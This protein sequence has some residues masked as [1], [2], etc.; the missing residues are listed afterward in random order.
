MVDRLIERLDAIAVEEPE[1]SEPAKSDKSNQNRPIF[2]SAP[3]VRYSKLAFRRLVR[4]YDVDC[5]YT[6]MIYAKCHVD[7]EK[8]RQ[9]EFSTCPEDRPLIVQFAT[10]DAVILA[11]A[12]ELV[13][14][15]SS[16]VDLNCGCPKSDVRSKG[17][18]SALLSKPDLLADMVRHVRATI[19]DPDYI[20]SL[21]IRI[22]YPLEKTVDL[23]RKAEAAGV[24][25]LAVHGRTPAQNHDPPDYDAIRIINES[26]N[27]PIIA[28][29]DIRSRAQALEV[30]E[31]TGVYG[32]MAA[33]GL[34][35]N[36]AMFAGYTKTPIECVRKFVG[37]AAEYDL[38]K[39]FT[40]Q[41]L[42]FMLRHVLPA[43]ERKVMNAYKN[44]FE[45]L[46]FL[47]EKF[48][49]LN[50]SL[51]G[52]TTLPLNLTPIIDSAHG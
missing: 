41:H 37:F 35:A 42:V 51:P 49:E 15:E 9:A 45:T 5:C 43:K 50:D 16:G 48:P 32:V 18:G 10:D 36:P 30:A 13:Y 31:R 17:F 8:A 1:I 24:S 52:Q 21:K 3:M 39:T 25:R 46:K 29:G 28:N 14:H 33:E 44:V 26:V 23:C 6:P 12:T 4:L 47:D 7:S 22:N 38:D 34:L 19:N 11:K 40:Q 2:V 20:V 27:V